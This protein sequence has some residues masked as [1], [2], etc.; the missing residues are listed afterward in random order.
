MYVFMS[1]E[2]NVDY[3]CETV[4]SGFLG[5]WAQGELWKQTAYGTYVCMFVLLGFCKEQT[6]VWKKNPIK[7]LNKKNQRNLNTL[8]L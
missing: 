2:K 4:N 5:E 3:I 7:H 1:L 8:L 6:F